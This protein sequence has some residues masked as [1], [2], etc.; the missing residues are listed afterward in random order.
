M[1]KKD[2]DGT[3]ALIAPNGLQVSVAESKVAERVATGYRLPGSPGP[4]GTRRNRKK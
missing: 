3:V 4:S 2:D 1:V